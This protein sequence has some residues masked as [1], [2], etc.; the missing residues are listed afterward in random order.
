MVGAG[1]TGKYSRDF[2]SGVFNYKEHII[3]TSMS[4]GSDEMSVGLFLK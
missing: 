1:E 2:S 3:M 4:I